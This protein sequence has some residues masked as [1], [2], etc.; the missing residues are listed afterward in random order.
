M[1]K[2]QRQWALTRT[3]RGKNWVETWITSANCVFEMNDCDL[4]M[5]KGF[6]AQHLT[7]L[8]GLTAKMQLVAGDT[9]S[10]DA[11]PQTYLSAWVLRS[12][13]GSDYLHYSRINKLRK[14]R[15]NEKCQKHTPQPATPSS[16]ASIPCVKIVI[17]HA[18]SSHFSD[19]WDNVEEGKNTTS[20]QQQQQRQQRQRSRIVFFARSSRTM[21]INKSPLLDFHTQN[22]KE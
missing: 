7:S 16:Q 19:S 1:I 22:S 2:P 13:S 21:C 15:N 14:R 11:T 18:C 17:I 5:V 9:E 20:Q 3:V 6:R 12:G 8:R 4:E 10:D